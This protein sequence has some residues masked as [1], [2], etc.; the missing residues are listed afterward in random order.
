[1]KS[2]L[3]LVQKYNIFQKSVCRIIIIRISCVIRPIMK[4]DASYCFKFRNDIQ[5]NTHCIRWQSMVL[6]TKAFTFQYIP[7]KYGGKGYFPDK[8]FRTHPVTRL[9]WL[10]QLQDLVGS[11]TKKRKKEKNKISL[12]WVMAFWYS[13]IMTGYCQVYLPLSS[14][15]ADLMPPQNGSPALSNTSQ[16]HIV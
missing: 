10:E 1:M 12:S 3:Y 6:T 8:K 16:Q 2:V 13:R 14:E 11:F 4:G 15:N 7:R 9:L 5:I